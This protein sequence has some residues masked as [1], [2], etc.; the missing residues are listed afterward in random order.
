MQ[1]PRS[2]GL[3][4]CGIYCITNTVNNKFYIGSSKNIY[5]RLKR[6]SSDLSKGKH[7]NPYLLNAY[8][9]Y[10][11]SAFTVSILEEISLDKLSERE[12]Y[13]ID[14]LKPQYNIVIE[15]I[16]GTPSLKSRKK[17]SKTLKLKYKLGILIPR[18]NEEQKKPI[19]IYDK[20]CNCL[21]N[22]DSEKSAGRKL[23]EL[24]PL[25]KGAH[26]IVNNVSNKRNRS[27][28]SRY[29]NHYILKQ[30]EL[31]IKSPKL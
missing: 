24:Y 7:Q 21:G 13:Y 1:I 31:C 28:Y 22:Y 16:R 14:T 10:G 6:H 9:K 11:S 8:K 5:H 25:I 4:K 19:T 2:F 15:V 18:T 27:T 3:R 23:Q 29:K 30:G 12:Q 17:I 20:D 26:K